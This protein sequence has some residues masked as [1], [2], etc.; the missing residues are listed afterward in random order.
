M[1]PSIYNCLGTEYYQIKC[2]YNVTTYKHWL[3][4]S[5]NS[6]PWKKIMKTAKSSKED[7]KSKKTEIIV[8]GHTR[9]LTFL[10]I[11]ALP[12]KTKYW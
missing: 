9:N 10:I 7:V 8:N 6:T 2:V 12:L 11:K 1:R 4:N 5:L 3:L